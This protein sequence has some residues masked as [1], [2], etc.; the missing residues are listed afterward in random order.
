MS[1]HIKAVFVPKCGFTICGS[2]FT[3]CSMLS[4]LCCLKMEAHRLEKYLQAVVTGAH[5][6]S[7]EG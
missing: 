5:A 2:K 6:G 3:L 1:N 4:A 7:I